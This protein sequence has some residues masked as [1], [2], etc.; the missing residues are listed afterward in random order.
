MRRALCV[1]SLLG[2]GCATQLLPYDLDVPAQTMRVVGAPDP[3]DGRPR[4]REIF[5]ALLARENG[6]ETGPLGC[7]KQLHRLVDEAP[8]ADS[9]APLPTHDPRVRVL[10]VPGLF[11]EC[12]AESV[13]PFALA[14]ARLR[15][16]GI[17]VEPLVVSGRSSADHNAG[18]IAEAVGA[19]ALAP[20]DRLLLVGHSKGA[21]DILHFLVT[22]PA[23]AA[24]VHAV[25]SVAGAIN[26]SPI[27]DRAAE[28]YERWLADVGVD[29]C[30][31]GDGG[32]LESLRRPVRM[33][34]LATHPLP[35]RV[36]RFSVVAFTEEGNQAHVLRS[37][38]RDLARID[39][40]NDGQLLFFDQVIPG[41]TL[42]GYAN[43]DHF[44]VALPFE[45]ASDPVLAALALGH[46]PFPRGV[47]LEAIV[48]YVVESM[49]A[50]SADE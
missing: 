39:P 18:Q 12:Y 7:E 10:I 36:P 29:A 24:R 1:L 43:A 4:F 3:V 5:C 37:S 28:H 47:L 22:Y 40:R 15:S 6:Y 34:W 21:V 46:A 9:P 20:D 41:A 19:L 13:T 14:S 48:L 23:L 45:S 38:S 25:V 50:A 17:R 33:E 42:L 26:G 8:A 11:G 27:A 31:P 35:P 2:L 49:N 16:R 30:P 44:A 32:A